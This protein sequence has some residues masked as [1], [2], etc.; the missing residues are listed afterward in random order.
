MRISDLSSDVCS[1]D[2]Q[3]VGDARENQ[4]RF[5]LARDDFDRKTQCR[6]RPR[7]YVG[8]IAGNA[9]SIGC[10]GTHPVGMKT[11]EPFSETFQHGDGAMDRQLV[12]EIGRASCRER[13]CQYV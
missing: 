7:Q 2:L 13:V 3:L 11:V 1:S 8:N 9:K 10:D 4:A 12:E 5:F 6:F